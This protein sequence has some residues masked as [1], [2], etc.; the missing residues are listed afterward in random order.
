MAPDQHV[1][2]RMRT[3]LEVLSG[4]DEAD[5]DLEARSPPGGS[6]WPGNAVLAVIDPDPTTQ[7]TV[8]GYT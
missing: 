8:T 4:G 6:D 3:D 5:L 2:Q 7:E 1:T